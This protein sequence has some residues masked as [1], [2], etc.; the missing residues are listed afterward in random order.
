MANFE[1]CS[2]LGGAILTRSI[3]NM[4]F[5]LIH[6]F[7]SMDH[8]QNKTQID[9]LIL[10]FRY[11]LNVYELFL[12]SYI[13]VVCNAVLYIFTE[14][15]CKLLPFKRLVLIMFRNTPAL[16]CMT[17]ILLLYTYIFRASI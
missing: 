17:H 13:V 3:A 16:I 15:V 1:I 14:L 6:N 5:K 12:L 10:Y 9:R 7:A 8:F 11:I 2:E 4:H